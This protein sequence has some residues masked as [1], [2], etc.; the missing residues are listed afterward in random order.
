MA[1]MYYKDAKAAIIK[2]DITRKETLESAKIW[3][4][5]LNEALKF[6]VLIVLVGNKSDLIENQKITYE[7][8]NNYATEIGCKL[9][10]VSAKENVNTTKIFDHIAKKLSKTKG[11]ANK[12]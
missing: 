7:V 8:A 4:K 2:F 6:N 3:I 12:I 11:N 9:I 5:E 1:S 10:F